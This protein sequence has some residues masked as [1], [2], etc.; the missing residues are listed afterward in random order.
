M[1]LELTVGHVRDLLKSKL[2]FDKVH[3][4]KNCT[5]DSVE[6]AEQAINEL[7]QEL[8]QEPG[9][10][11]SNIKGGKIS[12]NEYLKALNHYNTQQAQIKFILDNEPATIFKKG[13]TPEGYRWSGLKFSDGVVIHG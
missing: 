1:E 3:W 9:I 4:V 8:K 10:E 12:S 5:F 7:K 11:L 13:A 6:E 2:L